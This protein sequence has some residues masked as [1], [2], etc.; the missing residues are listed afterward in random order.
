MVAKTKEQFTLTQDNYYSP[1]RPHISVSMIKD[2]ML[3]PQ[4]YYRKWVKRDPFLQLKVTDPMK[5]GSIVD[6]L[7]TTGNCRYQKKVL[8]KDDP[9]MYEMQKEMDDKYLVSQ[10]Y[11]DQAVQ[12]ASE[13]LK[14]PVWGENLDTAAFQTVLETT[15][16]KVAICGLADR[17]DVLPDGKMRLIDLKVVNPIKLDNAR[18]WAWNCYDMKYTH[19]LALYQYM[20]CEMFKKKKEDIQC[21]HVIG[22]YINTG[23][24][25]VA[26]Y[27]FK[28][29]ILDYALEELMSAVKGIKAKNFDPVMVG[30]DKAE[31]IGSSFNPNEYEKETD[32][33]EQNQE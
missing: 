11:W 24:T 32:T 9:K 14:H 6:A 31:D 33:S 20:M 30:W 28:Q 10:V 7:L 22:A 8:K 13:L 19:Q 27:V 29:D 5:R 1:K 16:E 25:K 2:Y 12:V 17:I 3:D 15:I 23:L 18:K 26:A 21:A 4:Y